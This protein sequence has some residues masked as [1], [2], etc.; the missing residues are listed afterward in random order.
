V[1]EPWGT[2]SAAEVVGAG[3]GVDSPTIESKSEQEREHDEVGAGS[4]RRD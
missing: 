2:P 4:T 3:T 1:F